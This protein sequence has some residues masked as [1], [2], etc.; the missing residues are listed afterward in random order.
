MVMARNRFS[1]DAD[2][3]VNKAVNKAGLIL[4]TLPMLLM[5]VLMLNYSFDSDDGN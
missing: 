1:C 2:N 5:S 3:A 4:L